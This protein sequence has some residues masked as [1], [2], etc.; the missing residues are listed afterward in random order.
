MPRLL[1]GRAL[2]ERFA[3]YRRPP[4]ASRRAYY[5]TIS[6]SEDEA[7]LMIKCRFTTPEA[8]RCQGYRLHVQGACGNSVFE[9]DA[10][11]RFVSERQRE[12]KNPKLWWPRGYGEQN[13]Y[14]VKMELLHNGEVADVRME[15]RRRCARFHIDHVMKPLDEGEF[16][17]RCN[18][19]PILCKGSNWVPLDALHSRDEGRYDRAMALMADMGCNIVRCWGGNVV[20]DHHFFNL[21]DELGIMVW[22][23]FTMARANYP[24]AGVVFPPDRKGS[25]LHRHEAA[26]PSL[27]PALGRRQ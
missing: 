14:T 27:H 25:H 9:Y 5:A 11:A 7:E 19:V 18:G 26:Q 3:G 2:A 24:R 16:K 23:D 12:V 6:A 1:L 13:L 8:R 21:C 10:P 15:L 20:E 22:Q 17:V 4:R